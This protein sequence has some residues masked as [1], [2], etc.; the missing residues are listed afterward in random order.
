MFDVFNPV[1]FQIHGGGHG[2]I[3]GVVGEILAY[4]ESLLNTPPS[5]IFSA[6]MPG[7]AAMGNIHPLFV[8]FPIAFLLAFFL[9]DT[10]ASLAG[11]EEWRSV[12]GWLL[13]LG[14]ASIIVTVATGLY[15]A[16]TVPHGAN[17][18][19]IMEHHEQFGFAVL[20]LALV[21][22]LWRWLGHRFLHGVVNVLYLIVAA[23]MV[24]CMTLG[25]DLGG[26]MVYHYGLNVGVA[27]VPTEF[28]FEHHHE[29]SHE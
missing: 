7:V 2:G 21:L 15:A 20:T 1:T 12:A 11:K 25:A 9:L 23:I 19:D 24:V 17:V 8:H 3:A 22:S 18:H 6:L 5:D 16:A 29:H 4:L 14:T 28:S 27:E 26:L 13:Y 10:I